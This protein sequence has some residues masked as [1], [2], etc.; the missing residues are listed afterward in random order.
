MIV[1]NIHPPPT[2]SGLEAADVNVIGDDVEPT[3][4]AADDIVDAK[5]IDFLDEYYVM[6]C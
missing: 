3:A 6:C 2:S 1:E 4:A 5:T